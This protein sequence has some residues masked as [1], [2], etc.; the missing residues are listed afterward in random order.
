MKDGPHHGFTQTQLSGADFPNAVIVAKPD[1]YISLET[2]P[3]HY[4]RQTG[5][6]VWYAVVRVTYIPEECPIPGTSVVGRVTLP[7]MVTT[8]LTQYQNRGQCYI[9]K[10]YH[11]EGGK[12]S[13]QH[14][15]SKVCLHSLLA[16]GSLRWDRNDSL[17]QRAKDHRKIL[18]LPEPKRQRGPD[19]RPLVKKTP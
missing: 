3:E 14:F 15:T 17:H 13:Q 11:I 8:H 18:K 5:C 4:M 10:A 7:D 12:Y 2:V 6:P 9:C 1:P 19:G 16:Q